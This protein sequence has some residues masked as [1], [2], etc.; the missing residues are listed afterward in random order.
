MRPR[1]IL[2][3]GA[4]R[5]RGL[6]RELRSPQGDHAA[7][8]PEGKAEETVNTGHGSSSPRHAAKEPGFQR[9]LA[10]T[11]RPDPRQRVR[12]RINSAP[13]TFHH[14]EGAPCRRSS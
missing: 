11:P 12:G 9:L 4:E 7:D 10:G 6:V 13:H 3:G 5:V 1:E 2:G 14:D 8:E